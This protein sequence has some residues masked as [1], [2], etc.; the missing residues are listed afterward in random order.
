MRF[1]WNRV[2][3]VAILLLATV[4]VECRGA[5]I[6]VSSAAPVS[7]SE[8]LT[9]DV[10]IVLGPAESLAAFQM[11]VL[12]PDFL[13]ADSVTELGYF[14]ANGVSFSPG[15]IDNNLLRVGFIGD[16]LSGSDQM[17]V[18]GPLFQILLTGIAPGSGQVTVDGL[19][20][21]LLDPAFNDVAFDVSPG[22]VAAANAPVPEPSTVGLLFAGAALLA[23]TRGGRRGA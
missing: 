17:D 15:T 3:A 11:D 22:T 7:V 6:T 23:A 19:S 5:T 16:A 12:F 21:I 13:Q 20:V 1:H 2:G 18:S 10:G 8:T 14:A 4:G 9:V